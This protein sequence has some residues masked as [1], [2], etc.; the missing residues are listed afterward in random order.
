M[1]R[2]YRGAV[3]PPLRLR[4]RAQPE[5]ERLAGVGDDDGPHDEDGE[6]PEEEAVLLLV[7]IRPLEAEDDGARDAPEEG[8]EEE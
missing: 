4:L 8:D 3:L 6:D 2:S 7:K 1:S 5:A